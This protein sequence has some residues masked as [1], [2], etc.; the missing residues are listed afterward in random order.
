M[1][2]INFAH[3]KRKAII[4]F[5]SAARFVEKLDTVGVRLQGNAD[6]ELVRGIV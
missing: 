1:V 2:E 6:L 4:N 3:L 5:G